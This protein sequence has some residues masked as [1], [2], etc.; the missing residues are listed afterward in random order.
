MIERARMNEDWALMLSDGTIG[1]LL[2]TIAEGRNEDSRYME[3]L[4]GEKK[5]KTARLM[6]SL[7]AEGDLIGYKRQ[8]PESA[9]G[10][11]VVS[12]TDD[13]GNNRLENFG[14][15]FFNLDAESDYDNIEKEESS[16]L[17][18]QKALVPWTCST[19][20]AIP[21][22]TRFISSNGVEFIATTTI[23]SRNLTKPW[24]LY[25]SSSDRLSQFYSNGGWS[26]IKYQK[27]PVIQG[28][29]KTTTLG[30]TKSNTRFQT[31]T[32]NS[33]NVEAA[34]NSISKDFFKIILK[35]GNLTETWVEIDNILRAGPYD[36]VFEKSILRDES[37]IKIKFGDGITGRIPDGGM[38]V[39]LEYLETLGKA[40]NIDSKYQ[41]NTMVFPNNEPQIDPR[42]NTNKTFLFCTN[43]VAIQGG[44]DIESRREFKKNAPV[45]YLKSY[46]IGNESQYLD[47]FMKHSPINLLHC[48]IF[49]SKDLESNQIN[50]LRSDNID[51]V[52]NEYSI[53][54]ENFKVTAIKA[55]GE[56]VYEDT[57]QSDFIDPLMLSLQGLMSPNDTFSY[58]EPE[59]IKLAAG[60][61][62]NTTDATLNSDHARELIKLSILNDYSIYN[63]EFD[64]PIY[65]SKIIE[66][67][68]LFTWADSVSVHLE[69]LA[70]VSF[71]PDDIELFFLAEEPLVAIPFTFNKLFSQNKYKNGFKNCTVNSDYL[72]KVDLN[73]INGKSSTKDR[74]FFLFDNRI[75]ESGDTDIEAA[76]GLKLD[77]D[78]FSIVSDSYTSNDKNLT[79]EQNAALSYDGT[80][81]SWTDDERKD[82]TDYIKNPGKYNKEQKATILGGSVAANFYKENDSS[83]KNRQVRT[84]QFSYIDKIT[85]NEFMALAKNFTT[86]PLENRPFEQDQFGDNRVFPTSTVQKSL[87][88]P[89]S[90]KEDDSLGTSCLKKNLKYINH[91]DIQLYEMYDDATA[92]YSATGKVVIPLSYFEFDNLKEDEYK[93]EKFNTSATSDLKNN[94][95]SKMLSLSNALKSYVKIK[96]SAMPK[97]EEF[98][99]KNPNDIIFIDK[100]DIKVETKIK[101]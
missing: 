57:A 7:Q 49:N 29:Q 89:L 70:D 91:F 75:D 96:V 20:Y 22:G 92:E 48:K 77:D 55:N 98:E 43:D 50:Y 8:L 40:G 88:V 64:E 72:V 93:K 6:S 74:T 27:V 28:K 16:I 94:D 26:G 87:Q 36:R 85:D 60:I 38:T 90:G 76:K 79:A 71:E 51:T 30:Q 35:K 97:Q 23:Y 13:E 84:A 1:N 80:A 67:S 61:K 2:D 86:E 44:K 33:V 11:I 81:Y 34:N 58:V 83:Y 3:F 45:S 95:I 32:L 52:L 47:M 5:W 39:V 78:S 25:S 9:I 62:V 12:H 17:E 66:L 31:F 99:P 63:Q 65:N 18:K 19:C 21:K 73:F 101:Y 42:T 15:Y 41:I 24:S 59:Y 10:Y 100:E 46:T 4:Y 68:S 53:M 82:Y 69:A 54:A 14:S 56:K 37:G